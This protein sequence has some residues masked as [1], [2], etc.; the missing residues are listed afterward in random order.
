MPGNP[1]E[2]I[3]PTNL[4][5]TGAGASR[6][7]GQFHGHI[8][9]HQAHRCPGYK[10][11]VSKITAQKQ[12]WTQCFG[13]LGEQL[14]QEQ[15]CRPLLPWEALR[16]SWNTQPNPSLIWIHGLEAEGIVGESKGVRAA[17]PSTAACLS[18]PPKYPKVALNNCFPTSFIFTREEV[19]W[20]SSCPPTWKRR[21]HGEN[22]ALRACTL[23]LT[24]ATRAFLYQSQIQ[25]AP[26]YFGS[27]LTNFST[28]PKTAFF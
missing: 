3:W 25:S 9:K 27:R 21:A 12:W 17:S 7:V 15:H 14:F 16:R 6:A 22:A 19:T 18:V 24:S 11:T 26:L 8:R 4:C 28:A 13:N 2:T 5:S 23:S 10:R 20:E 1:R